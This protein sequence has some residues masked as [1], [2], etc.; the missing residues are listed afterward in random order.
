[1]YDYIKKNPGQKAGSIADILNIP[2]RTAQRRIKKLK[3]NDK[4]KFIGSSKTG[5]YYVKNVNVGKSGGVNGGANGGISGGINE[6]AN[7]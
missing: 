7:G 2:M 1:M 4:I 5:G 3:D 6:E